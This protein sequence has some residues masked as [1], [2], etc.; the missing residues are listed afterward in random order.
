MSEPS[1]QALFREPDEAEYS[2]SIRVWLL[3]KES[4]PFLLLP[5]DARLAAHALSLYPA[6]RPLARLARSLLRSGIQARLPVPVTATEFRLR[7]DDPFVR[8]LQR[9][10]GESS[11][12][13][14][15]FAIS[16]GNP[17]AP[18]RRFVVL[19]FNPE[20]NPA[21]IVKAG[22]GDAACGL[23]DREEL[24]LRSL[25]EAAGGYPRVRDGFRSVRVHAF[26]T[27]YIAGRTALARDERLIVQLLKGWID[28]TRTIAL[29]E[30][31]TWR[32]L[33]KHAGL[34][35]DVA[36]RR[37]HPALFHG[38][39]APWNIRI[40][41]ARRVVALDWERGEVA[42]IPTWDWL[43]FVI[44]TK[45]LTERATISSIVATLERLLR[46]SEFR[47]YA[48]RALVSGV[49]RHLALYYLVY[50]I[51]VLKQSAGVPKL[52]ALHRALT[53]RWLND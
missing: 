43:H 16:M 22:L 47:D 6:Q 37:V 49:E 42:G 17:H 21:A 28:E 12:K 8:F 5:Q 4:H 13:P 39:F 45:I 36:G 19:V 1:W 18:G 27:E 26:A 3:Q 9:A 53:R 51:T 15:R 10:A 2:D 34:P 7:Q 41:G 14:V 52:T 48:E 35:S 46:S 24:V 33:A 23:I 32:Q 31:N 20:G 30:T 40:S 11:A 50:C 29:G 38:D 25:P 44:Q